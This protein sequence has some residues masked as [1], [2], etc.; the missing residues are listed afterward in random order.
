MNKWVCRML[1][2]G[3]VGLAAFGLRAAPIPKEPPAVSAEQRAQV[4]LAALGKADTKQQSEFYAPKVLVLGGSELL[5]P[6][7]GVADG[8]PRKDTEIDRGKLV[9]GYAKLKAKVGAKWVAV[10][11]GITKDKK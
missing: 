10:W 3:V 11:A 7:W 6:M 5:K 9:E 4:F 2:G 8:D 1:L